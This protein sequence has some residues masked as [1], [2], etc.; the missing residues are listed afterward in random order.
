MVNKGM[1]DHYVLGSVPALRLL[2]SQR[3]CGRYKSPSGETLNLRFPKCISMQKDHMCDKGHVV[4]VRVQVES[5]VSAVSLLDRQRIVLYKSDQQST[6]Q[7]TA[8]TLSI[9]L[10]RALNKINQSTNDGCSISMLDSDVTT[11]T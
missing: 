1:G 6:T 8:E 5:H 4:C 2:Q 9:Q 7:L 11:L 3:F 10:R